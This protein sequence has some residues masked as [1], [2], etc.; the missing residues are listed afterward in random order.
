MLRKKGWKYDCVSWNNAGNTEA[1]FFHSKAF[2]DFGVGFYVTTFQNQA[3]KWAFRK[4][5]RLSKPAIVNVYEIKDI[6]VV[7]KRSYGVL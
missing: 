3:E 7:F 1:G 6:V 4:G 5:M 2:L